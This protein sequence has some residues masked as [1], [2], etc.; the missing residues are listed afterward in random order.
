M[1]GTPSIDLKTKRR[2]WIQGTH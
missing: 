2:S 1:V